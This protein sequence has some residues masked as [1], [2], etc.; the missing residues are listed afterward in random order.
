MPLRRSS[1]ALAF[2]LLVACGEGGGDRGATPAADSAGLAL[3]PSAGAPRASLPGS[4]PDTVRPEVVPDPGRHLSPAELD[5]DSIVA[6]YRDLYRSEYMDRHDLPQGVSDP[7]ELDPAVVEA[8]QRR[9]ALEWGY[10]EQDAWDQL[11]ADLTQGQRLGLAQRVDA[12]HR[13]LKQ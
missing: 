12:F 1:V 9:A 6:R 3:P 4:T 8:A 7:L 10:V 13:E 11:L 2:C 5:V